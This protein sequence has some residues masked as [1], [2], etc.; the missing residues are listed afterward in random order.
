MRPSPMFMLLMQRDVKM[1]MQV[2]CGDV[3]ATLVA[4]SA[5]SRLMSV[6]VGYYTH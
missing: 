5:F 3:P 4:N 2:R 6:L 1:Y